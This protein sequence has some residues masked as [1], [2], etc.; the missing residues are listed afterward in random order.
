MTTRNSIVHEGMIIPY[1]ITYSPRRK[2]ISI[3][4]HHTKR[5]EIKAPTGTPTS[6]IHGLAEKKV[7]W[8]VKRL[9]ILDSMKVL[10]V[11]RQYREGEL[12]FF[13]GSPCTLSLMRV[14]GTG[15]I[16]YDEGNLM[17]TIPYS[18]PDHDHPRY[19]RQIVLDWYRDQAS[20][21]IREQIQDYAT[22]IGVGPPSFKLK[23]VRRR[24]GSCNHENKL[25]FNI[26]LVMAPINLI[27]YV[28]LH[29]LCHIMHKNHSREFWESLREVMPDY[30]ERR[31]L[32]KREGHR[33]VL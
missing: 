15:G 13:L 12:F 4:V 8:I 11:E 9:M 7:T 29:E 22:I 1:D 6:F 16:R 10:Q 17:V 26:R 20:R 30:R 18:L 28:V 31:N 3:I 32:L 24:W 33:Y 27:E 5:V 19:I 25:N 23:N 2:S 21:V 14:T